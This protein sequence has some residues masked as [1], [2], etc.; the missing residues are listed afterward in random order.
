[1]NK[2]T[3]KAHKWIDG[4]LHTVEHYFDNLAEAIVFSRATNAHHTKVYNEQG[5]L[6]HVSNAQNIAPSYA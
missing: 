6:V 1:M 4:I 2:H 5:N 3:V